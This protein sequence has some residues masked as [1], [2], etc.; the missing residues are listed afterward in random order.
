MPLPEMVQAQT[1]QDYLSA[2]GLPGIK[3]VAQGNDTYL[4]MWDERSISKIL[5]LD[6][7]GADVLATQDF[8]DAFITGTVNY[9]LLLEDGF[10]DTL[11]S[12]IESQG[13]ACIDSVT[14]CRV[15]LDQGLLDQFLLQ[16][17]VIKVRQV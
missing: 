11:V 16:P 13:G 6:T 8:Q 2:N 15:T 17:G 4:F 14:V 5:A 9:S 10:H 12:Y 3:V 1:M 7:T